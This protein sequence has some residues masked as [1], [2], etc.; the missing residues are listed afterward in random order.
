M[1]RIHAKKLSQFHLFVYHFKYHLQMIFEL[2]IP[3]IMIL[4]PVRISNPL[5]RLLSISPHIRSFKTSA[6]NLQP[7][8]S[9][10]HNDTNVSVKISRPTIN[11]AHIELNRPKVKNAFSLEVAKEFI[12]ALDKLEDDKS[13]R[14]IVLSGFGPDLTSGV[15][16][17]SFMGLYNQLQEVE[18]HARKAKL[19][20]SFVEQF[21]APFKRMFEFGK[22][23][24]CVIHGTCYGLGIEMAACSDIRY[25]SKD[26]KIAIR[27][28]LIGIAAD[29]GSLQELPRLVANQSLL[30][31]LI[32][33]GR[34][35]TIDE[36]SNIGLVSC[37]CDTKDLTIEAA[38][39][40]AS[41]I[42]ERSPVAV[43]GSK[44]NLRFSR[45]KPFLVGLDYNAVWN[46]T[47][48]QSGDVNKAIEAILQRSSEV[49]YDPY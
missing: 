42:A 29:V 6:R 12:Q 40:T 19:L 9:T 15:D 44:R 7:P 47:M 22:P 10:T 43:Q 39:K 26:A 25:C 45:D 35:L 27:E 46:M 8:D 48:M 3:Q 24:I 4:S 28:V 41:V 13:T 30:R 5:V 16:L 20:L 36:A 23:I 34:E 21:Q 33:T 31:E 2:C 38:I 1:R 17:R 37:V 32:Y 14:C 49:D 11:V 18:D